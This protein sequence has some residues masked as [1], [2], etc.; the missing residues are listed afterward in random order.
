M[1]LETGL[2]RGMENAQDPLNDNFKQLAPLAESRSY[3][4]AGNDQCASEIQATVM[5]ESN[6]NLIRVGN[7]V[8]LNARIRLSSANAAIMDVPHVFDIP[9]G[10]NLGKF[11]GESWNVACAVG[12]HGKLT[13]TTTNVSYLAVVEG[14]G[15][16]FSST[17]SGNHYVS[18][19]WY[20]DDPMPA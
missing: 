9:E 19:C 16:N 1:A 2:T 8:M 17:V 15:F 11:T 14:A 4:Y 7:F 13:S 10:F 3:T 12:R 5:P 20:T 6:I 18:G